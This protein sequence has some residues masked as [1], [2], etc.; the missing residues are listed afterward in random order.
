[1][2]HFYRKENNES[3]QTGS[4]SASL[5]PITTKPR[6]PLARESLMASTFSAGNQDLP[7]LYWTDEGP[8]SPVQ[9]FFMTNPSAR[10]IPEPSPVTPPSSIGS[11]RRGS[12]RP[13]SGK[14]RDSFLSPRDPT[15]YWHEKRFSVESAR[16][17]ADATCDSKADGAHHHDDPAEVFAEEDLDMEID[18]L[19]DDLMDHHSKKRVTMTSALLPLPEEFSPTGGPASPQLYSDSSLPPSA[20]GSIRFGGDSDTPSL[21]SSSPRSS[22]GSHLSPTLS[23][24]L[25]PKKSSS[26]P[27]TPPTDGWR[28]HPSLATVPE[29]K[30]SASVSS[31]YS[32]TWSPDPLEVPED[33]T[34]DGYVSAS[35]ETRRAHH[36]N[37]PP[38]STT[39][40]E[41]SIIRRRAKSSIS[42]QQ[43]I[44]DDRRGRVGSLAN[45]SFS[46]RS[47]SDEVSE[48][49]EIGYPGSGFD[50]AYPPNLSPVSTRFAQPGPE[51]PRRPWLSALSGR[52]SPTSSAG[53]GVADFPS[54]NRLRRSLSPKRGMLQ[55]FFSQSG[56]PEQKKERKRSKGWDPAGGPSSPP[57]SVDNVSI[58]TNS[59][60]DKGKKKSEK[61]EKRAQ[62][63]AQ[64]KAKQLKVLVEKDPGAT[65]RAN[66]PGNGPAVMYSLDG[67]V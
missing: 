18:G 38:I 62:L 48:T 56:S 19:L 59:S 45:R 9:P 10:S 16:K 12:Q 21:V 14:D 15:N 47:P 53:P 23:P 52:Y 43:T 35:S 22:K 42:S 34:L 51:S 41:D 25:K 46:S 24:S 37:L 31:G 7:P 33:G 66:F 55:S 32:A 40:P 60:K 17:G 28:S 27:V 5:L 13:L 29:H 63:A 4:K 11:S 2:D 1:M 3:T 64:L 67:F 44:T 57:R 65:A 26:T 36:T 50:H 58:G 6:N 20:T 8:S 30:T 49:T 54:P 39:I 61:A